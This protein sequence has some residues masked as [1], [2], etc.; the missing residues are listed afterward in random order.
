MVQLVWRIAV[1][2]SALGGY[3]LAVADFGGTLHALSQLASL[4]T[5]G[6]Y[7][8]LAVSGAVRR[9]AVWPWLTGA[10]A[11]TLGLVW[12]TYLFVLGGSYT[13]GYSLL[14]H[15]VTPALVVLDFVVVGPWLATRATGGGRR[16]WGPR[17]WWPVTWLAL[18]LGYLT[19]YVYGDLDVYSFLDPYDPG[20]PGVVAAFLGATLAL[21]YALYVAR[22][23]VVNTLVSETPSAY[24]RDIS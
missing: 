17:W 14:E 18:P 13:H 5:G 7:V 9:D 8:L 3:A 4:V 6:C 12:G 1:A 16:P 20:Y 2:A 21:A 15:L 23:A 10:L 11:T 19:W 24:D 22:K